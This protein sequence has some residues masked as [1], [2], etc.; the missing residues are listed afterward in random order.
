MGRLAGLLS[1]GIGL[2]MEAAASNGNSKPTTR[3]YDSSTYERST[4]LRSSQHNRRSPVYR[5]G[6]Q[7]PQKSVENYDYSSDDV[8]TKR[9]IEDDY[10][11]VPKSDSQDSE[12]ND[13]NND[14][15]QHLNQQYPKTI[16]SLTSG[17]LPFPV[18]IPQRRPEDKSRG[19]LRAYAPALMECGIDQAEFISFIESFNEASKSSPYLD[20]VNVAALGVGFAPGIAPLVVSIA[21]P[22]AIRFAKQAQTNHQ[23]SSYLDKANTQ[24]FEKKGLFCLVMTFKPDQQSQ[25][26]RVDMSSS[27]SQTVQG[28]P[29][30]RLGNGGNVQ[31]AQNTTYGE[32]QLPPSAPLIF[33]ESRPS[34]SDQPRN[35]L[36]KMGDFVADYTDRRAQARYAQANP[37]SALSSGPAPTFA[38]RFGDP[39]YVSSRSQGKN[40]KRALKDQRKAEKKGRR[41]TLIGGMRDMAA[42]P[43]AQN[44][45]PKQGLLKSLRGAGMQKDVLYLMIVNKPTQREIDM[46][47]DRAAAAARP[48]YGLQMP[49]Q[50]CSPQPQYRPSDWNANQSQ[51][52]RG[53]V[54]VESYGHDDCDYQPRNEYQEESDLPPRYTPRA[55]RSGYVQ[56]E[57]PLYCV[58][59]L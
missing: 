4:A 42:G 6:W 37:D 41:P 1:N 55:Q 23:S 32:F 9:S 58:P 46:A 7:D 59:T 17:R 27:P 14:N 47:N 48:S 12:W 38:S 15:G 57:E 22:I 16:P 5:E 40:E 25:V 18:I 50:E 49:R 28:S 56:R 31:G 34:S 19:W 52:A 3:V 2:A 45:A 53:I 24:F 30:S 43:G 21:V 35:S 10:G 11:T 51:P 26:L 54:Q 29:S 13:S 33:P 8:D 36:A 39:S 20:V 44:G